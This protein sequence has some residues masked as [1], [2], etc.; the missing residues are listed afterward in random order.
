MYEPYKR[1][2]NPKVFLMCDVPARHEKD[3]KKLEE[4][5]SNIGL[6]L[7][8]VHAEAHILVTDRAVTRELRVR[9]QG[10][11][12][13]PIRLWVRD[14]GRQMVSVAVVDM[15]IGGGIGRLVREVK[16]IRKMMPT[17]GSWRSLLSDDNSDDDEFDD[18]STKYDRSD[19]HF[20]L[21]D[22]NEPRWLY[23]HSWARPEDARCMDV[24]IMRCDI[25]PDDGDSVDGGSAATD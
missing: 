22:R 9:E 20:V 16:E 7:P 13:P 1:S 23:E 18:L 6:R 12:F 15:N 8:P 24:Y 14:D 3:V 4:E 2:K 10:D 25:V 21:Y 11:G 5:G 17:R 19:E